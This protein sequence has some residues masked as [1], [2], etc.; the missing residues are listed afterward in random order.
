MQIIINQTMLFS[1]RNYCDIEENT[2]LIF[3]VKKYHLIF[4]SRIMARGEI[5]TLFS[6]L[7]VRVLIRKLFANKETHKKKWNS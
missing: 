2:I 4:V 1:T 5:H 6:N 3:N 7:N